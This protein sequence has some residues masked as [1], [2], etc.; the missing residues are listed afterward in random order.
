M[1]GVQTCALPISKEKL[2]KK[3][4]IEC[5]AI[6]SS[7]KS[8]KNLKDVEEIILN[9]EKLRIGIKEESESEESE[10]EESESVESKSEESENK[11]EDVDQHNSKVTEEKNIIEVEDISIKNDLE[12]NIIKTERKND[13]K[14]KTSEPPNI[15]ENE[16]NENTHD[17]KTMR[18]FENQNDDDSDINQTEIRNN[19]LFTIGDVKKDRNDKIN[20]IDDEIAIMD[21]VE[22]EPKILHVNSIKDLDTASRY[23]WTSPR[24]QLDVHLGR[25]Q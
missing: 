5:Y 16:H 10:N 7:F 2:D 12:T 6:L 11:I 22:D 24:G 23:K 14:I 17:I 19:Q 8:G 13:D 20:Q 21:G 3:D 18:K 9:A 15:S 1:T 4:F 25:L